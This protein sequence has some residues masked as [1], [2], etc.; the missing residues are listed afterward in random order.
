M[1]IWF[2]CRDYFECF[3]ESTFKLGKFQHVVLKAKIQAQASLLTLANVP[4]SVDSESFQ[5]LSNFHFVTLVLIFDWLEILQNME[6]LWKRF[7]HSLLIGR[8]L[9]LRRNAHF[10][11][12]ASFDSL[13]S[14]DG[15]MGKG[16][17]FEAA[18]LE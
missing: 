13:L 12:Y 16:G 7:L 10:Q 4:S 8:F 15:F 14:R 1:E 18:P 6:L 11:N 17:L 9:R 5:K 3:L 2:N